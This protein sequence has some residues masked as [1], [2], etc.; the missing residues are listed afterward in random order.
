MV[1]G[2]RECGGTEKTSNCDVLYLQW[3]ECTF[4][5]DL[6]IMNWI[7]EHW[8]VLALCSIYAL[9]LL[10]NGM[11]GNRRTEN[12]S[13]YYVGG[14]SMGG[15]AIGIS[16]F[17]T[18]A[19]TNS[20]IGNAGQ[21][22]TYGLPF[23]LMVVFMVVF[24]FISWTWIAPRLREFTSD[25]D[26]VTLPDFFAVRFKSDATRVFAAIVVIFGSV[27]YMTAIF[28]GVGN[29]F[30]VFF[31]I[32]YEA[33]IFIVLS[34]VI[35]YTASGG[36]ISV[37]RTDVIQGILMVLGAIVIFAVITY[38]AGGIGA[39]WEVSKLGESGARLFTWDAAMPFP[40]MLGVLCA[41]SMKLLVEPRQL[42]RFFGLKD[43]RSVRQGIWV[44][45]F[46]IVIVQVCL[47]PIGIYAH[48]FLTDIADTD[49]IMPTLVASSMFP[50]YLSAF[51]VLAM[52][53]AAMSSLDSVLLVAAST[54][55]RDIASFALPKLSERSNLN[56]TRIF[57]VVIALATAMIALKP[58]GGVIELTIFSGS[59]YTVC[60]FPALIIGL[61]WRRGNGT[62]V[63]ASMLT[64][65][66][67]LLI[68]IL[69]GM[70][71]IVHEIFPGLL[72]SLLVYV[73]VAWRTPPNDDERV[74][75][76]FK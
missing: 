46:G 59:V 33:A 51:L 22:Y 37:V 1:G 21:G 58:P 30:E 34:I 40:V 6:S 39:I 7:A 68:W 75:R 41:G 14:R 71:E 76:C 10:Y 54:M 3:Q 2:T 26:S 45:I 27:L 67:T 65:L 19:S 56:L 49:L 11:V 17:A 9:V 28:K 35:F 32:P 57:V 55:E 36:F 61:H 60:F 48:L 18:Y 73:G 38:N 50:D 25:W 72:A 13:D 12:I 42:S 69:T 43:A 53:A 63:I 24:A 15:Y 31:E 47:L 66:L 64:G 16:F 29:L 23:L 5:K 44:S 74:Q 52:L 8:I 70:S 62:A 20:F 4:T